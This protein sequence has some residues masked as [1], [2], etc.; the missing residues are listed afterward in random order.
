MSKQQIKNKSDYDPGELDP[1]EKE[2]IR[3]IRE[4]FRYGDIVISTRDGLPHQVLKH[5][6]FARF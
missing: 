1:K 2:L 4:R 5:T 3:L 6:E